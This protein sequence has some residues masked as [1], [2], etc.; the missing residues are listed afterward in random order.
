VSGEFLRFGFTIFTVG[1]DNF[2]C[3]SY[4]SCTLAKFATGEPSRTPGVLPSSRK[5]HFA[6]TFL[7]CHACSNQLFISQALALSEKQREKRVAKLAQ[8]SKIVEL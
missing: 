7:C 1:P 3:R 2:F 6:S 8:V 5:F 4:P